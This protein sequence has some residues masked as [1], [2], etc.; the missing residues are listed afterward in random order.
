MHCLRLDKFVN[1]KEKSNA[2]KNCIAANFGQ[3]SHYQVMENYLLYAVCF[4]EDSSSNNAGPCIKLIK[5]NL[6]ILSWHC[7]VGSPVHNII[8]PPVSSSF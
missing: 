3:M 8:R 2:Q 4:A 1:R 7:T 6:E 5:T